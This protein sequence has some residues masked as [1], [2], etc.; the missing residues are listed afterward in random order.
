MYEIIED[1]LPIKFILGI[2]DKLPNY[3][4]AIDILYTFIN[5]SIKKGKQSD[6]FK[7]ST[8]IKYYSNKNETNAREG[9]KRAIQLGYIEPI[10]QT[11]GNESYRI[12]TNP[13]K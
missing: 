4:D 11:V 12:L 10:N 5:R 13:F 3:P 7:L 2:H 8:L 6:E 9:I 1:K